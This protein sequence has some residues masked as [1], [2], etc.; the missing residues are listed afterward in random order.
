MTE[1]PLVAS[2]LAAVAA[3]TALRPHVASVPA[4]EP[5]S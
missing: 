5:R 2:L 1:D 4:V 3:D